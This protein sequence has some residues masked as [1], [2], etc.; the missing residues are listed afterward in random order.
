EWETISP[1]ELGWCT[2]SLAQFES[3]LDE[4]HSKSFI[5][6]KDGKIVLEYYFDEFTQDS[7]WYWASAGKSLEAFLIGCAV[8]D[9]LIDVDQPTSDFLGEGWSTLTPEQEAQISILNQLTMTTGLDDGVEDPDCTDPD[10]L[11]FLQPPGQRWAYHNA[12]YTLLSD[13]LEN[14]VGQ[15]PNFYIYNKLTLTTGIDVYYVPLNYNKVAFSTP[16]NMAKFGLLSM[17]RGTWNTSIVLADQNYFNNMVTPSQLLNPSY[18]YLWWLNGQSSYMLPT[19]QLD[20]PGSIIPEAPESMV[21]AIGKNNQIINIVEDQG[22]VW[23]RMGEASSF[24]LVPT[25]LNNEIWT[26]LNQII[27]SEVQ[28]EEKEELAFSFGPN[29]CTD[30]LNVQGTSSG[31][32]RLIDQ[33]GRVVKSVEL[34]E[35][36]ALELDIS[37]CARGIYL[38]QLLDTELSRSE[39]M[40]LD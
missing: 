20:F 14:A 39:L 12:P 8:D 2:D 6:L 33:N 3:F 19:L 37:D 25:A 10:C 21:A 11:S 32:L 9:G 36:R 5:L 4:Q 7:L 38:L 18:G 34:Q 26:Y 16:R 30:V 23:I 1:I 29:P 31:L 24:D 28:I 35:G 17:N 13:V 27:C 15:T 22:L 40:I